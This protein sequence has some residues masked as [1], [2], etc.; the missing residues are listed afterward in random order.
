MQPWWVQTAVKHLNVPS[1]GWVTTTCCSG[2]ILPPPTAI[3]SVLVSGPGSGASGV[4]PVS[5]SPTG[6][7]A[8]GSSCAARGQHGR[9]EADGGGEGEG[10]AAVGP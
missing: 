4:C 3:S 5:S 2:K 1:V 9:R 6:A 8:A 7:S 10:V